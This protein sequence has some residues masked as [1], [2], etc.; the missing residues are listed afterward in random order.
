MP[1]A[2]DTVDGQNPAPLENP[3]VPLFIGIY[4]KNIIPGFV[5]W[6]L[7][8]FRPST[9]SPPVTSMLPSFGGELLFG[10]IRAG[11]EVLGE[12][13]G[14]YLGCVC[15][16]VYAG[17][18]MWAGVCGC[19]CGSNKKGGGGGETRPTSSQTNK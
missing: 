16:R 10:D 1:K 14:E 3:G 11:G 8:G 4:M 17:G 13:G 12:P 2:P 5:R 19:G 15:M 6:C 18:C 9:V 7:R